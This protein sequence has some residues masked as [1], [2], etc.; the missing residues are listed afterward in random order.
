MKLGFSRHIFKKYSNIE[1]H[2]NPFSG[3]PIVPYGRKDRH[4]EAN[5]HFLNF[6]NAPKNCLMLNLVVNKVTTR[7]HAVKHNQ[8]SSLGGGGA[9]PP[10]A[11]K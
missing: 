11:G 4:D 5:S 2:K 1:F 7:L 6:P 10:R 9:P 8:E 3:S